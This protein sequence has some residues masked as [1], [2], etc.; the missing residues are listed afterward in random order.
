WRDPTGIAD[1]K[2]PSGTTLAR[3]WNEP[4]AVDCV[5][6]PL[7]DVM[8]FIEEKMAIS[9]DTSR[10]QGLAHRPP[11]PAPVGPPFRPPARAR[12]RPLKHVLGHLLYNFDCRCRLEGE[13]LVILPPEE[14]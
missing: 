12:A 3:A 8:A 14:P 6:S 4:T 9:I 10:V 5:A 13:T 2:P 1:I 11:F 7:A